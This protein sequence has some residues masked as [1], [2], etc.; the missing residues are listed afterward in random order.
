MSQ[1]KVCPELIPSGGPEG[2]SIPCPLCLFHASR[3]F[4]WW[5]VVLSQPCL[6]A[7][8]N[9]SLRLYTTFS[10]CLCV[11]IFPVLRMLVR[12]RGSILIQCDLILT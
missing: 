5:P 3:S 9:R 12:G 11:P 4:C 7:D 8:L 10:L 6:G 2:E 1:I